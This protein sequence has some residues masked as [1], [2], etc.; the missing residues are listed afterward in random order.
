MAI[1]YVITLDA[2]TQLPPGA[3]RRMIETI[4]HPLNHVE[5]DPA[6]HTRVRGFSIIQPRVSISLPSATATRFTRI[7]ADT[8]GTD[9]YCK[10]VSD[11]QQDLFGEGIFHGKAIYD[12]RAFHES[13]GSRFPDETLLSHDLIEG[14]Y[15]GVALASDIELFENLPLDYVSYCKRM[16]R[17][18]RGD[19]QIAPWVFSTVPGANGA[20]E[21]NS[22][23][24]ISRF[25]IFD[26]LRR[27][28]V[29]IASLALLLF[30]WLASP[31][32][33]VWSLVIGSAIAILALAPL[34]DRAA[35]HIQGEV[36]G[37]GG[38]ADELIR[39]LVMIAFLPHQAWVSI[40]AI[41]RALYRKSVSGRHLL[42][43]QTAEATG[44]EVHRHVGTTMQQMLGITGL[45]ILLMIVLHDRGALGPTFGFLVLWGS[46]P[47]LMR[48][49]NASAPLFRRDKLDLRFLRR[50]ARRT[51]RYFDDLV[52][53]DSNWLPPDNSQLVLRVEVAQ[54]TSPTNIGLWLTSALA[55]TDLGYLT[56]DEF[57]NRCAKTMGTLRGLEHYEG[58]LL[59]WYDIGNR[60][61]LLPRYV[62]TVDSGNF[63]ACLWVLE[64]GCDELLNSPILD[65]RSTRGL[66]DTLSIL[67]EVWGQ[68]PFMRGPLRALRRILR[69][70]VEGYQVIAQIRMILMPVRQL[71]E[72]RQWQEERE[73]RSYWVKKLAQDVNGWIEIIERYLRWMETLNTPPDSLL[74]TLSP[75]AVKLRRRAAHAAPSLI[76]L[77]EGGFTPMDDILAWRGAADLRPDIAGWLDQLSSEYAQAKANAVETVK[78]MRELSATAAEFSNGTNM[79]L[80]YDP[81]RR[82]FGVGYAV[83]G[84]LEFNSHYD[85]LASE[86]RLASLVAIAKNDVPI[87]HWQAMARP[88]A[89]SPDGRTLLSWSGTMFEYLMPLL[90]THSLSNSLLDHACK[91]AVAR[92]IDYGREKTVPWGISESAYSAIDANKIYQYK[93]FGVPALALKASLSDDL[94]VS[95]YSTMLALLVDPVAAIDN[96]RRLRQ[97]DLEGPM[98]YYE[99][100]DF[101]RENKR[102]GKRGVVTYAYMAHH[103]GMSLLSLN[104]LL[105]RDV[106][107]ERFHSDVRIRAVESL[108]FERLP[109]AKLPQEE[110]QPRITPVRTITTEEP[111]ERTWKE[112][113]PVPRVH[114]QGNGRYSLMITNTG[115]GYSRSNEFDETRWRSDATL[116]AWGS[117]VYI[118]DLRS[119]T[120]WSASYHPVGGRLGTS[121][122]SFSADRAEFHRGVL[123][124]E[125]VLDVTVAAEDEVELRRLTITNR[126]LRSR[127]L[128]LTSY[129]ELSLAPHKADAA[130]PAFAKMFV[131]TESMGAAKSEDVL[132]AH[133]RPRSPEDPPI[134]AAH[135]IVGATGRIQHETDRALFLGRGNGVA[136]PVALRQ[137]LSG[138]V[139]TVLD[140]IFSLR[141]TTTLEARERVE[142]SFL[143]VTAPSREA[144]LALIEKYKRPE[145]VSRTFEMAWTRAQLEFRYLGIGPSARASIPGACQ[146]SYLSQREAASAERAPGAESPG[147]ILAMDLWD[148]RRLAHARCF[149]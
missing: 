122:A 7:F 103:Q 95:P 89:S 79:G 20:S 23:P 109:I 62:S 36:E 133:R 11:A 9:P 143:T 58:H 142:I 148:L 37:W 72:A 105:H 8:S 149:D 138:S 92:Q 134:W 77:A 139:G 136:S 49:L 64:R 147:T 85:L 12:V 110:K 41:V 81:A 114:L 141:C 71:A 78:R 28:M 70:K 56:A 93:A 42:E 108:L 59:N 82:L 47:L 10:A 34:L 46:S 97:F 130:H 53:A 116:D 118:R 106:M 27:S 60:Q 112:D 2:D 30:G 31:A 131:E 54:R 21:P 13:V 44:A 24:M 35:R 104:N 90:F 76:K 67:R 48:W 40:D 55:A 144:L 50:C 129:V 91:D 33:G 87:E 113:T 107:Q 101:T 29:P 84:P 4:S 125:T 16:H 51:W 121:S 137:E 96:L 1:R 123:G 102:A 19:W 25:R 80:L 132:I 22:L 17:W 99:S 43:W 75:N 26:N 15:A 83:G 6:T 66:S 69:G 128:E 124:M 14:S 74:E 111:A 5:I 115:A 68:D 146:P 65:R 140:P 117:V 61:P 3:A 94:V 39:S 32:P 100:I 98:G 38:A 127:Q 119:D 52:N 73:E 18:I 135:L 126:T 45:S 145:A 63:L 120:V 88:L 57:L 86:C